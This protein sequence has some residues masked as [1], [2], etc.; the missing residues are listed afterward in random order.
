MYNS[1]IGK[2]NEL[3]QMQYDINY[4]MWRRERT[5]R[6]PT[7]LPIIVIQAWI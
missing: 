1:Y 4:C 6:P 2:Y 3:I 5:Q 7:I